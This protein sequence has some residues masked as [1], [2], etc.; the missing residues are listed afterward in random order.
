MP[1]IVS[2]TDITASNCVNTKIAAVTGSQNGKVTL[3]YDQT[4]G[5]KLVISTAFPIQVRQT[6]HY[7]FVHHIRIS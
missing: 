4:Q 6:Q 3:Y 7:N 1:Q 5:S 2:L